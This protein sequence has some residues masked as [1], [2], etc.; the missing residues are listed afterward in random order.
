MC[1][2]CEIDGVDMMA[3]RGPQL[4]EG[5]RESYLKGT[6]RKICSVGLL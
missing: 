1:A 5:G 3:D 4:G 2:Q 6:Y